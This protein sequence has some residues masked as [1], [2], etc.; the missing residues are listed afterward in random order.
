MKTLE[1]DVTF[2]RDYFSK[3]F[4][5]TFGPDYFEDVKCRAETDQG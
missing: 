3:H 4:G 2:S 1:L 5:V